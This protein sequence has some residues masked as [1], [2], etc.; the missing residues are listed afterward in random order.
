MVKQYPDLVYAEVATGNSDVVNGIPQNTTSE[1]RQYVCR[2]RP[3][4]AAK[5]ITGADGKTVVY[6]GTCYVK[7][8]QVQINTGD[9]VTVTGHLIKVAVLQVFN[10]Q[11]RARIIL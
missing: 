2:Y 4:T 3:N 11:T 5:T 7:E 8:K 6:R 1:I 10:N 9:L